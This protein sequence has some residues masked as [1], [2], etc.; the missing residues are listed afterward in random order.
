MRLNGGKI[1]WRVICVL[2][3]KEGNDGGG[4]GALSR[5]DWWIWIVREIEAFSYL[6]LKEQGF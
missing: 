3:Q 4:L 6:E 5:G 1:E 2:V